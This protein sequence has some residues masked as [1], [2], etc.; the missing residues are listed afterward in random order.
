MVDW[1]YCYSIF[2]C[3]E[4]NNV[5]RTGLKIRVRLIKSKRELA[6]QVVS[7]VITRNGL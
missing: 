7:L 2:S 6:W 5:F 1:A 3:V 4:L